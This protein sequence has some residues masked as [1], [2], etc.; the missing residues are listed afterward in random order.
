[1]NNKPEFLTVGDIVTN[2]WLYILESEPDIAGKKPCAVIDPGDEE[3]RIISRLDELNWFPRYILLTHGHY[4][5]LAAL[6]GLA[7][8]FRKEGGGAFPEIGIHRLDALYLG[9][10]SLNA[11]RNCMAAAGGSP[12][13]VDALWKPLPEADLLFEEGDTAG[14]FK[15]IHLPGHSPGSAAFFDEKNG[16]LFSGDTL[17][18]G[19]WGRTDLPGGNERQLCQSLARLLSMKG[20]IL[21]CPG[22]GPCTSIKDE[23]RIARLLKS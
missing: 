1:M 21:V 18:M 11:H 15:V 9:K 20:E 19:S 7:G 14:P 17:F 22:H 6:P 4:D 3:G 23:Q 10:D 16:V 8:T 5:H 2:C 13:Y 12:A